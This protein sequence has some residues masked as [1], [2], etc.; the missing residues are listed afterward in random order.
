MT[1]VDLHTLTGAYAVHALGDDERD[2]FER[3]LAVCEPCAQE[4]RELAATA[5]RLGLAVATTPSPALRERVLEQITTVRQEPPRVPRQGRGAGAVRSGR[6]LSRFVL[7]ACLAAAVGFGGVAVWQHGEAR[8]AQRR[9]EQAQDRSERLA[10][11]LAS[12]DARVISNELPGGATATVVVSLE[13]GRAAFLASDMPPPPE[14]KV[15]QLWFDHE[16]TMRPAGLMDPGARDTAMLMEGPLDGA[17]GMGITV[18]P[19]GGSTEPTSEPVAAMPFG[20]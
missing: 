19:P 17:S 1:T 12:G 14:G 6:G 4:V 9:A 11:V 7:A 20:V 16:G 15:Y 8:D 18:E 13:Q 2:A 3:H 5:S 10:E